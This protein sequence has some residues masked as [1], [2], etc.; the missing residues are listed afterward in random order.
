MRE[1]G[2]EAGRKEERGGGGYKRIRMRRVKELKERMK[3]ESMRE[4]GKEAG[5]KE[6]RS[7]RGRRIGMRRVKRL[8]EDD[9]R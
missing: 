5:R 2:K 8:K 4:D 9:E 6:E 1:D 3:G 7:E